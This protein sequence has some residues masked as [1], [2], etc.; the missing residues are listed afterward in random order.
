MMLVWRARAQADLREV[1][2][3]IARYSSPGHAYEM[4][5]DIRVYVEA[6]LDNPDMGQRGERRGERFIIARAGQQTYRCTYRVRGQTIYVVRVV[7]T[8]R[9]PS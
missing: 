8:R 1:F 5:S 9:R 6:L 3:H 7:D 2:A 4:L